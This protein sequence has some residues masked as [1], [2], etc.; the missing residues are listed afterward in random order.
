MIVT[1]LLPKGSL[2]E[3]LKDDKV[4]LSFK[5]RMKM[6]ACSSLLAYLS[7]AKCHPPTGAG[8]SVGNELASL[9]KAGFHSS[10]F[11]DVQFVG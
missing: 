11:E 9:F 6:V 1:E 8:Y 4:Q 5:R 7:V 10:R 3:L 2:Y